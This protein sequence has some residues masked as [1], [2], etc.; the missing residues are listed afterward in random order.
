M[1]Y[2]VSWKPDIDDLIKLGIVWGDG[3][4][5]WEPISRFNTAGQIIKNC[6]EIFVSQNILCNPYMG[7]KSLEKIT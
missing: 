5:T 1:L 6:I 2:I 3:S 4:C 7:K